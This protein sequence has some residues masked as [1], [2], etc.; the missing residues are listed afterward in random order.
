MTDILNIKIDKIVNLS[1]KCSCGRNHSI[2]IQKISI[3]NNVINEVVNIASKYK[4]SKIF[5][6]ADNNTYL[7]SGKNIEE[8]LKKQQFNLKSFVFQTLNPLVPDEKALGRLLVEIEEDTSL[9]ISIGSGTLND[10]ARILSY[11]LKIPYIIV[12]TAPSMD[13]YASSI[14]P[15]IINGFKRT[16]EAVYPMAIIADI[17]AMKKAPKEMITAGFGDII[18][19]YTALTDWKLSKTINNEYYCENTVKLVKNAIEKCVDNVDGIINREDS[20]IQSLVEALILSGVAIG[21]VGNSRPASGAE[22]HLAHYWEMDFLSKGRLH[23][24]HGNLVAVGTIVISALYGMIKE[25]DDL[26]ID[27]PDFIAIKNLLRKIGAPVSP[28]DLGIERELFKQSIL[29]AKEVRPRY[30]VF[31]LAEKLGFLEEAAE[32]LTEMFYD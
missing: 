23:P 18:G 13:G 15:L 6:M 32:R 28:K 14:S 31:H 20:S 12:G 24:L 25:K 26:E 16:Y 11:K 17:K 4:E 3:S 10:L 27:I 19:K 1:F 29:H 8:E 9:I 21:L 22:H 30:T 5:L 7:I 2:D